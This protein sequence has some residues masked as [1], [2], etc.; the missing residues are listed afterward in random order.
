MADVPGLI[1]GAAE[2][3]GLGHR[4]LRHVERCK[5]LLFLLDMAGTDERD[6]CDD[7]EHLQK[8]LADYDERLVDKPYVVVGNKRDEETAQANMD[9][10]RKRFPKIEPFFISAVLEEGLSP[11]RQNLL[12]HLR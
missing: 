4:F 12:E 11:L 3:R 2:N 6:P 5:V 8:E 10:F 1:E 7:F 9:R